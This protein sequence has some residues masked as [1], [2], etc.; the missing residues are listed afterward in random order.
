MKYLFILFF[1]F[2]LVSCGESFDNMDTEMINKDI[3][4]NTNIKTPEELI[5][6]YYNYPSSESKPNLKIEK[7]EIEK[8]VFEITLIHDNQQDDS[9]KAE[10]IIMIAEKLVNKWHVKKIRRNWKCY[11]GRGHT[12]WGTEVCN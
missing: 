8:N 1:T 4:G 11:S 9:Q 7:K 2:L 10:K 12:D 3:A 6:F 5:T